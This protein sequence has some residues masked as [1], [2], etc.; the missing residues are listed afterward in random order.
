MASSFRPLKGS[1][2]MC[3]GA[4]RDC[5]ENTHTRLIHC[6]HDVNTVAGFRFVGTDA[7]GFN[8]WAV[9]DGRERDAADWS[10]MR[11]QRAAEREK[12]HQEDAF[13]KAQLLDAD[14]R[15]R[16]IRKIHAQLGLATRHKQNLRDR[17]LSDAD[18]SDGKFFSI[19]PWQEV[20]GINP[21]LAGVDFNGRKLLI[22]QSGIA[23]PITDV[24]GRLIG[25]QTRFDDATDNKYK[26][27]TSQN[28]KRPNGPTAHLQN[29]ELPL[30]CCRPWGEIKDTSIGV[31]E[32]FLKTYIAARR[33]G[34]I[35]IGAAGANFASSPQQFKAYLDELSNELNDNTVTLYPDAG[36]IAN[37]AVMRHYERIIQM[38]KEWSYSVRVAWWGQ[39][40]KTH[41][42][43]DELPDDQELAYLTPEEFL[44]M[45]VSPGRTAHSFTDLLGWLPRL[46][47]RFSKHSK[48]P[49]GFGRKGEI[50]VEP[51]PTPQEATR[52]A[53]GE[54]L[55]IWSATN[56]AGYRHLLDTSATGT[57]KSYNAGRLTNEMFPDARQIIYVSADHR[58]P[59]TP[60]LKPWPDLEAR[61][62]GLYRDSFG[63][64]RRV[65]LEQPYVVPPNCG[66]NNVI[67]ALR[68]KNIPGADTA[69]LICI[70]CPN[71]EPCRA[72]ATYNYLNQR[73]IA[74]QQPRLLA[75]PLSLP[76]PDEYDYQQVV[77]V[78][79]EASTLL[80]AHTEIQVKPDD[81]RRTITD[82]LTKLPD[83]FKALSPALSTLLLHLTYDIKPPNKFGWSDEQL[84]AAL[85][86]IGE[87]HLEALRDALAQNPEPILNT[88][89]EHGV[90][91]DDLPRF[92]RKKFTDPDGTTAERIS[93]ELA[94]NWL[95]EFLDVLLG[96]RD[97]ALRICDGILT[98][99]IGDSRLRE[100]AKAASFN[101]Y[102]DAT[103]TAAQTAKLLQLADSKQI[104]VVQSLAVPLDNLEVIQ[105]QMG[106]RLGINSRRH[107]DKGEDTFLELRIKALIKQ[108]QAIHANGKLAVIDFKRHT[109]QGDG[110]YHHYAHSR[111]VNDMEDCDVLVIVGIACPRINDLADEFT[112][113]YGRR[114]LSG[115]QS[116]KYPIQVN[117]ETTDPDSERW[118]EMDDSADPEFRAFVR[119]HIRAN[120]HQEIGRLR[121]HRRRDKQLKVYILGDYPLD[122][123]VTLVKASDIT[124]DAATKDEIFKM[125]LVG[126]RK[127][128]V[129]TGQK[130]TQ[131]ALAKLTGY[132][133]QYIS[134]ALKL[135]PTLLD[136]FNSISGKNSQP[137][138]A[139]DETEWMSNEYL[140]LLAESPPAE[141]L[142]GVLN[143]FEAYGQ[144]VFKAIWSAAPATAQIKILEVLMLTLPQEQLL[145]LAGALG[146]D[147]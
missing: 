57:G 78:W 22:G 80:K 60:T 100:I 104:L 137:D 145:A 16:N 95:P 79:E 147:F 124:L 67:G 29:G 84:R 103:A 89:K 9:D 47:D 107:N 43:V 141:L 85:G 119:R 25:W 64:L 19:A 10:Q 56:H 81:V 75:H 73:A 131:T 21:Q 92:V 72:G 24:Q 90:D 42:D 41:P 111:S 63:K 33:R 114:P 28:L 112:V 127:H 128:L 8:M 126:A 69:Q 68:S 105:V 86:E 71:L 132:S 59:A 135:L 31:G 20:L 13:H 27:P 23:I 52:Y 74:L 133:Q 101:I 76:S 99:T 65:D 35:F 2:S 37:N 116:I 83:T 44:G 123:P 3:N 6:R 106:Q 113:L 96:N 48:T 49:W 87:L 62:D 115:T 88:T 18:I 146:V 54:R 102:L 136:G 121:A 117:D 120:I 130:V 7:L 58:N 39:V 140:P 118:F 143:T 50:E 125:S 138:P 32:G 40:D 12:R 122:I 110:K 82:L 45:G 15:D 61:H 98:I 36:G 4:R 93:K 1:C 108:I 66:R 129:E 17:R 94:L 139:P 14:E 109:K 134:R 26:W 53:L 30:T 91:V 77:L 11:Q 97:G 144:R 55:D 142:E 5:R 70:T 46:V 34:Q 51:T 38:A